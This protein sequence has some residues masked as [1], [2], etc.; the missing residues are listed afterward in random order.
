[1]SDIEDEVDES[2]SNIDVVNKYTAGSQVANS[3]NKNKI[4]KNAEFEIKIFFSFM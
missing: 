4:K 3:I 1:M 2:L